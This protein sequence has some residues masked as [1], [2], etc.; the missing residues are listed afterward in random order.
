MGCAITLFVSKS[1]EERAATLVESGYFESFS[2]MV[3][4]TMRTLADLL[5]SGEP[6]QI[7][8]VPRTD[9]ER[10]NVRVNEE[11]LRVIEEKGIARS[12]VADVAM[13]MYL[14]SKGL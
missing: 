14:R 12:D 11:V 10:R 6:C 8:Y 7:P 1:I 3:R 4:Y 13:E 9:R 2:E 5:E